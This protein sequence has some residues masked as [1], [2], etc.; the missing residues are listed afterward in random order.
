M[1]QALGA[2]DE[3]VRKQIESVSLAYLVQNGL[4]GDH[5]VVD[6]LDLKAGSATAHTTGGPTVTLQ[7]KAGP[8]GQWEVGSHSGP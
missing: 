7:L 3:A 8:D 4:P 2:R 6:T 1:D 5:V